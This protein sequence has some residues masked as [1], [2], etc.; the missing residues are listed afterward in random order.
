MSDDNNDDELTFAEFMAFGTDRVEDEIGNFDGDVPK[1]SVPLTVDR[2]SDLLQALANFDMFEANEEA[3][4]PTEAEKQHTLEEGVVDLL[5]AISAIKY[6]YDLDIEAA[7]EDRMQF[8]ADFEAMQ[9]AMQSAESNA[10]VQEAIEEHMAEHAD[11]MEGMPMNPSAVEVGE[12]VDADDYDAD[13]DRDR[14][15]A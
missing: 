15:I 2:A 7:I 12:N 5:L 13:D 11:E 6:E 3:D 14:H 10:E 8:V 1:H 9:E 4:D